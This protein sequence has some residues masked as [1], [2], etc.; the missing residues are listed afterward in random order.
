MKIGKILYPVIN[1]FIGGLIGIFLESKLQKIGKYK[2]DDN[3]KYIK[4]KQYYNLLNQWI[5]LEHNGKSISSLFEEKGIHSIAI[6]GMGEIGWRL[7]EV[8][9]NTNISVLYGIDNS[10][11]ESESQFEIITLDDSLQKVDAVIVTPVFDF[12]EISRKINSI[13]DIPVVSLED[14]LFSENL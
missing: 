5:W 14:I 7:K 12:D 4:F 11:G 2:V 10:L 1:I 8:L 6:Y 13:T 9:N 3:S